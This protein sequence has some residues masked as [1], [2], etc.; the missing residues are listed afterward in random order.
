MKMMIKMVLAGCMTLAGAGT[1]GA[2]APTATVFTNGETVVFLG[3]SITQQAHFMRFITDFYLTRY[4][5][6][7]IR[8]VNAGIAGNSMDG[9]KNCVSNDVAPY[10]PTSVA[11]MYGMN[12][13]WAAGPYHEGYPDG[14]EREKQLNVAKHYVRNTTRLAERLREH[15]PQAKLLFLTP[16]VYE[17]ARPD[18]KGRPVNPGWNGTL[19]LYSDFLRAAAATGAW[20]VADIHSPMTEFNRAQ[21]EINPKFSAVSPD[22]RVHPNAGGGFFMAWSFLKAQGVSPVVSDITLD[23]AAVKTVGAENAEVSALKK[24][25]DGYT[26]TV[27]EKSLP[28]PVAKDAEEIACR[29]PFRAELNRE[30]FRVKGLAKGLWTLAIDGEDVY[31]ASSGEFG[32]GVNLAKNDATPQMRQAAKVTALNK[33]RHACEAELRAW[34]SVRW[35]LALTR[36][37]ADPDDMAQV[38]DWASKNDPNAGW[39]QKR[40]PAYIANWPGRAATRA[41]IDAMDREL[42]ALRKPVPRAWSLR[43]RKEGEVMLKARGLSTAE[44]QIQIQSE[45]HGVE[46]RRITIKPL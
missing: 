41:K 42:D 45:G 16:S 31:T 3:D 7:A 21:Q 36:R 14:K 34:A 27:L 35:W 38:K 5:E 28:F 24:T 26:F 11:I 20:E 29:I 6:R 23:A 1:A 15:V 8:W 33:E 37:V 17:S 13:A 12:D 22:D 44:G 4:P 25:A 18:A 19:G 43:L 2:D 40:V 9:G 46:I 32:F 39:Y 30:W 10:A